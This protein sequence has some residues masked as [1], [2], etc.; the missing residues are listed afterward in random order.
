VEGKGVPLAV[1]ITGANRPDFEQ[2][3]ATLDAIVIV[4]P[5]PQILQQHLCADNGYD[6]EPSRAAMTERGYEIH[7][8]VKGLDTTIP[9]KGDPARHPAR[10][11]VVE[12]AHAWLHKFR[13]ILVRYERYAANYLGLIQLACAL[14]V[15][16]KLLG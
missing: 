10:R 3:A 7:I 5:D 11:W 16:R 2:T 9:P 13:K 15:A 14:I 4:R 1:T 12:R 6:Y 8:P